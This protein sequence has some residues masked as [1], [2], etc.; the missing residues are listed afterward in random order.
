MKWH[1]KLCYEDIIYICPESSFYL[2]GTS[3]N[4]IA[5]QASGR[6]HYQISTRW[7]LK[8][9]FLHLLCPPTL[10]GFQAFVRIWDSRVLLSFYQLTAYSSTHYMLYFFHLPVF[11]TYWILNIK[12]WNIILCW[13]LTL[14]RV[15]NVS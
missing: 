9:V 6:N 12:T 13:S 15:V 3:K 11:L 4:T 8:R 5:R 2:V 7:C 10:S 14:W 1:N